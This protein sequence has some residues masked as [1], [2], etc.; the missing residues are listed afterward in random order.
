MIK[1]SISDI[2]KITT[3]DWLSLVNGSEWSYI[4]RKYLSTHDKIQ[5]VLN[6]HHSKQQQQQ[7]PVVIINFSKSVYDILSD[8]VRLPSVSTLL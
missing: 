5:S 1:M 6:A 7:I 8:W 2:N 3:S 4:N